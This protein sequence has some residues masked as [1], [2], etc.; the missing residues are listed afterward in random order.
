M[1]RISSRPERAKNAP[2]CPVHERLVADVAALRALSAPI[3]SKVRKIPHVRPESPEGV[4]LRFLAMALEDADFA[5]HLAKK[6]GGRLE[7]AFVEAPGP[8]RISAYRIVH[9]EPAAKV[10]DL[11][12][13]RAARAAAG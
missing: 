5:Y 12:A 1:N 6:Y 10:I 9:R 2:P 7:I 13:Y 4:F 3:V 8:D 11:G